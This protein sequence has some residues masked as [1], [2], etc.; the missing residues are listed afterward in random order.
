MRRPRTYCRRCER[1]SCETHTESPTQSP[2]C[3]TASASTRRAAAA[4][5]RTN[6]SSAPRTRRPATRSRAAPECNRMRASAGPAS[7]LALR[8]V[9]QQVR[10]RGMHYIGERLRI[11]AQGENSHY[12]RSQEPEFPARDI[13]KHGDTVVGDATEPDTFVHPQRIRGAED[14]D[15]RGEEAKPEIDLDRRENDHEFTDEPTR[16]R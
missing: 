11:E 9:R 14:H 15:R 3:R 16:S 6:R 1:A 12:K 13:L 4:P 5:A 7:Q 8:Y 2:R 10:D